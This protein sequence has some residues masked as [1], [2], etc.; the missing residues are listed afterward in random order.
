[1]GRAPRVLAGQVPLEELPHL[2]L[3][4]DLHL[5]NDNGVSH[6]A[7]AL[8]RPQVVLYRGCAERNRHVTLGF[9]DAALYSGAD[10]A[11]GCMDG[12]QTEDVLATL[13]RLLEQLGW[14]RQR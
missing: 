1:M 14:P 6:V 4:A 9:R 13:A 12:I 2:L 7:G 11:T 10:G 3:Q 8:H 5:T